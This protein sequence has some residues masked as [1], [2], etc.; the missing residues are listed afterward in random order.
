MVQ[1]ITKDIQVS[2]HSSFEGKSFKDNE[3]I[4]IFSY[5]VTIENK[6]EETV[7][8]TDRFWS[9]YDALNGV[10]IVSGEGVV[11]QTPTL[12]P[13][14]VY[15][16]KSG[17]FLTAEIGAMKGFYTMINLDTF[18]QFKVYIPNFQLTNPILSN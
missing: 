1:Q 11:G 16:Y 3:L 15:T 18:N 6:G 8:L 13:K 4:N 5:T 12:K 17:C 10:E 7:K 9:I 14:D 2:V